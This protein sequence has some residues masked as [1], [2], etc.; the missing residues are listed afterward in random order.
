MLV[1]GSES[2]TA[3]EICN[4]IL[5]TYPQLTKQNSVRL[6]SLIKEGQAVVMDTR[7]PVILCLDKVGLV[8]P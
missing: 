8:V 7:A 6:S 5:T 3:D 2:L 1:S 4:Y